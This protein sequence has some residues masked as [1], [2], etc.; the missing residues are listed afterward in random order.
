MGCSLTKGLVPRPKVPGTLVKALSRFVE[1]GTLHLDVTQEDHLAFD[2][3]R[4]RL[5]DLG[6]DNPNAMPVFDL[7]LFISMAAEAEELLVANLRYREMEGPGKELAREAF[8]T[9][10]L[11]AHYRFAKE[12]SGFSLLCSFAVLARVE[13]LL[14]MEDPHTG[15]LF[16][17]QFA[18][19]ACVRRER[20]VDKNANERRLREATETHVLSLRKGKG[21][22]AR[23][24][25]AY[26]KGERVKALPLV[27]GVCDNFETWLKY[28][29]TARSSFELPPRGRGDNLTGAVTILM[30]FDGV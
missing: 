24:A 29:R 25:Y 9:A 23:N 18:H 10:I 21:E 19:R 14:A 5:H 28:A 11:R 6:G 16:K 3:L 15:E 22:P 8:T 4:M 30:M 1:K 20:P 7:A 12:R 27:A 17:M 13:F 2:M 26:T